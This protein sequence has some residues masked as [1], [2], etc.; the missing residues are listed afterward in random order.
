MFGE[1]ITK[2]AAFFFKDIIKR[3]KPKF[4]N[5][6]KV[7]E[8]T[9]INEDS[10]TYISNILFISFFILVVIEFILIYL[11]I[12]LSIYFSPFT[13]LVTIFL[14]ATFGA[15]VFL[16][17]YKFPYYL[18]DSK[19]KEIDF[20][21]E[22]S[23][24]HLAVLKDDKLTISDVLNILTNLENNKVLTLETQKI[25]SISNL[26]NNLKDTLKHV[27]NTTYSELERTFFRKV[28][29][30]LDK[31]EVLTKVV[32]EFLNN[33]EQSRKELSEQKKSRINLLF[34][35]NIFLFFFIVILLISIFLVPL[36]QIT[37]K[38]ILL[39]IAIVFPIVEFILIIILYK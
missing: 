39:F 30:V 20:E 15:M 25:I 3:L 5:L 17:L 22:Q 7:L 1:I 4:M 38:N 29:D 8:Y 27:V 9:N 37:I 12:N 21:I 18:L 6:G 26:N 2:M 10:V 34:Q 24:R 35:V 33:L 31:K 13:F 32:M 14:S 36:T 16:L 28:I 23:I 19:K 11:M